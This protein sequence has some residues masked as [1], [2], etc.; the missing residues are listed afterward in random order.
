[1]QEGAL[2]L[3]VSHILR[4]HDIKLITMSFGVVVVQLG[5]RWDGG[6]VEGWSDVSVLEHKKL[7]RLA[8]S[9]VVPLLARIGKGA[10]ATLAGMQQG[11][12]ATLPLGHRVQ[13]AQ[14]AVRVRAEVQVDLPHEVLRYGLPQ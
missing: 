1:M 14:G 10:V 12:C 9:L 3:S 4:V 13:A 6:K 11:G 7:A 8:A 2:G 5:M